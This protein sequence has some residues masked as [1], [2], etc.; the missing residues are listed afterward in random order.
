MDGVKENVV[1]NKVLLIE[2]GVG[3]R[4]GVGVGEWG[5]R[6]D[7]GGGWLQSYIRGG[8]GGERGPYPAPV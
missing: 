6:G 8:G 3:G 4:G 2:I 1:A 5:R 7:R